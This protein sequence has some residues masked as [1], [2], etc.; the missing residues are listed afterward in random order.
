MALHQTKV[1]KNIYS[2]PYSVFLSIILV[3]LSNS[4]VSK[5]G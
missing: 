5:V 4:T 2:S 3:C 1:V